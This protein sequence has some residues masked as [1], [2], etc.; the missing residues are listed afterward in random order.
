MQR[1][2]RAYL[3]IAICSWSIGMCCEVFTNTF[4]GILQVLRRFPGVV[5]IAKAFPANQEL[6]SAIEDA[7]IEDLFDDPFLI[8]IDDFGS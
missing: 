2:N 6:Q 7:R 5:L 8:A 4:G 1:A 3:V